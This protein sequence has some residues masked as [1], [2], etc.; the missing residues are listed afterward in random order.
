MA[1]GKKCNRRKRKKKKK[2]L[3]SGATSGAALGC[4]SDDAS[5]VLMEWKTIDH[6]IDGHTLTQ[7][8]VKDGDLASANPFVLHVFTSGRAAIAPMWL[9]A[10][11]SNDFPSNDA[12]DSVRKRMEEWWR[13]SGGSSAT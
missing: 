11:A 4:T 1:G 9:D 6:A 3:P 2:P 8:I 5:L 7:G 12:I 13:G 10:L